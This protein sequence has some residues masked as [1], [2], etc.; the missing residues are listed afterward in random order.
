MTGVS[1]SAANV[2]CKRC[3]SPLLS[4]LKGDYAVHVR[5][6]VVMA[7]IKVQ[8]WRAGCWQVCKRTALVTLYDGTVLALQQAMAYYSY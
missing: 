8:L 2:M 1:V 4:H 7:D 6:Q 3:A 5:L